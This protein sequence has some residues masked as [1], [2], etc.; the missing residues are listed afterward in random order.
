[1]A[2][3]RN[4]RLGIALIVV[5]L[6]NFIVFA[7]FA[8]RIDRDQLLGCLLVGTFMFSTSLVAFLFGALPYRTLGVSDK[9]IRWTFIF[10]CLCPAYSVIQIPLWC[11][12][13]HQ[14]PPG[15][16]NPT[17]AVFAMVGIVVSS[18]GPAA[19]WVVKRS[20]ERY[21]P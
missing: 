17:Q 18:F 10:A 5:A 12:M 8:K 7:V 16:M 21:G 9:V 11:Y 14:F 20:R 1:M 15:G 13:T 4:F 2:D 19:P 6:I 3:K